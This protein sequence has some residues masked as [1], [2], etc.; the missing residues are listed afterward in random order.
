MQEYSSSMTSINVLKKPAVYQMIKTETIRQKT[1]SK[2]EEPIVVDY[3]CGRQ[4]HKLEGCRV[5][6]YDPYWQSPEQNKEALELIKNKKAD[7]IIC[8]NVLCV[9]KED[10]IVKTIVEAIEQSG[11]GYLFKIYEG[12]KTGVG[13]KSKSDC[14]QRNERTKDYLRFFKT[15]PQIKKNIITNVPELL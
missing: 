14:W 3:G 13:A 5:V 15:C 8:S 7:L 1:K 12:N 10:E 11:I 6:G 4:E 2:R 9:I